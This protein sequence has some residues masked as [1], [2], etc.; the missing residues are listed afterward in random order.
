MATIVTR[1]GK[2]SP[3]TNT[4][5]DNNFTNLNTELGEKARVH[6]LAVDPTTEGSNN[7]VAFNTVLGSVWKKESGTWN[8][9]LTVPRITSQA[10]A[11]SSTP[12]YRGEINVDTTNN[13]VY[14]ATNTTAS[15]DWLKIGSGGGGTS[16][17]L[18]QFYGSM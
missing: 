12:G 11:P 8:K 13:D 9:K 2:E 5:V 17:R 10:G 1:S 6:F 4:E 16:K 7:D 3:L 15:T 14:I 18:L